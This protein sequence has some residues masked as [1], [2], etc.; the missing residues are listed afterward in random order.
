MKYYDWEEILKYIAMTFMLFVA[1]GGLL[2]VFVDALYY[3]PLRAEAA[4][5]E[6][7]ER[8]FESYDRFS[9]RPLSTSVYGLKCTIP[10][11]DVRISGGILTR[12][13]PE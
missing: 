1:I 13:G 7:R 2:V 5:T 4:I 12:G 6:C 8:G 11:Y 3:N 10:S 9:A